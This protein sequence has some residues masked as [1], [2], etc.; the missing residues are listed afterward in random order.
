[1]GAGRESNLV[2]LGLRFN[3]VEPLLGELRGLPGV[4]GSLAVSG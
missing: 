4:I 1:L 3:Q 2:V